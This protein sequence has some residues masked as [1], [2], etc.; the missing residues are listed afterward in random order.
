MFRTD[1]KSL[2]IYPRSARTNQSLT[3]SHLILAI[4]P[5]LGLSSATFVSHHHRHLGHSLSSPPPPPCSLTVPPSSSPQ[6]A[7]NR[8]L[9]PSSR[10]QSR[11]YCSH[12]TAPPLLRP[13]DESSA[14]DG[15]A[16]DG[17]TRVLKLAPHALSSPPPPFLLFLTSCLRAPIRY[18]FNSKFLSHFNFSHSHKLDLGFVAL[19]VS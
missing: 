1:V 11:L 19:R 2:F 16:R 4:S 7:S 3:H 14:R 18:E 17:I 5:L 10:V 15:T 12:S 9:A 13:E 6:L 8:D